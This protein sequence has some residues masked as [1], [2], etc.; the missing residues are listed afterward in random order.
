MNHKCKRTS[1]TGVMRA[2]PA[3]ADSARKPGAVAEPAHWIRAYSTCAEKVPFFKLELGKCA[4][5][6][7]L[8]LKS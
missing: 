8:V 2:E 7:V 5:C 1:C 3:R 4:S 6:T